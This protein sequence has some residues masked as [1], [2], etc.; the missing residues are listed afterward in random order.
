MSI[1]EAHRLSKAEVQTAVDGHEPSRIDMRF[2]WKT[3]RSLIIRAVYAAKPTSEKSAIAIAIAVIAHILYAHQQWGLGEKLWTPAAVMQTAKEHYA[4]ELNLQ[5]G[6]TREN[7]LLRA[8]R[9][10]EPHLWNERYISPWKNRH[11]DPLIYTEQEISV[12]ERH[13]WLIGSE[14][15]FL[16]FNFTYSL[17][18]GAGVIHRLGQVCGDDF[19]LNNGQLTVAQIK[20]D[21]RIVIAA[22]Q[23]PYLAQFVGQGPE[24]ILSTEHDFHALSE[25][26]KRQGIDWPRIRRLRSTWAVRRIRAGANPAAV[27]EALGNKGSA[28]FR[29]LAYIEVDDSHRAGLAANPPG[30]NPIRVHPRYG[31]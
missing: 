31:N 15:H 13:R 12:W 14:T 2:I 10:M 26:M 21:R 8:A 19:A 18:L 17:A 5:S 23:A 7:A 30:V 29:L 20:P 24:P 16:N 4:D 25:G 27:T 3:H 11:P 6:A 9:G 22:D 1:S 28:L